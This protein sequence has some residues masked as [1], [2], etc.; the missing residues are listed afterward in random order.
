MSVGVGVG[1][2]GLDLQPPLTTR[3]S[4]EVLGPELCI[5]LPCINDRFAPIMPKTHYID[6]LPLGYC[7][8]Y[9]FVIV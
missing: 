8:P 7:I 2:L 5:P 9:L 4:S 3:D 6:L 1:V